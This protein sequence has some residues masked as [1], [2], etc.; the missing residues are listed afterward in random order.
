MGRKLRFPT[1]RDLDE[2]GMCRVKVKNRDGKEVTRKATSVDAREIIL[3]SSGSLVVPSADEE[4]EDDVRAASSAAF[5]QYG[6]KALRGFCK[7][8]GLSYAGKPAADLR[9]ALVDAGVEPPDDDAGDAEVA[10]VE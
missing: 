8:A 5:D 4:H 6:I 2:N 3:A 1:R 7:V 10:D 9:R